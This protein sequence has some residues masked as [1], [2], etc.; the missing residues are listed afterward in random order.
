MHETRS[1]Y[2]LT[3][4]NNLVWCWRWIYTT[5]YTITTICEDMIYE[6]FGKKCTFLGMNLP[7]MKPQFPI[8]RVNRDLLMNHHFPL[9]IYFFLFNSPNT[10]RKTS[11]YVWIP[12]PWDHPL[13]MWIIMRLWKREDKISTKILCGARFINVP[14]ALRRHGPVISQSSNKGVLM[15]E[16]CQT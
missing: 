15:E 2:C 5:I 8:R 7:L 3:L 1:S 13:V 10:A 11:Y 16:F 9:F 12:R 4:K 6:N 14:D